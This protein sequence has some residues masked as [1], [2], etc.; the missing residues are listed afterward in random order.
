[1]AFP[2]EEVYD[3][4]ARPMDGKTLKSPVSDPVLMKLRFVNGKP[5]EA[6]LAPPLF[7]L[8]Y[9]AE[10][11]GQE[12]LSK[13]INASIENEDD[14]FCT[15]LYHEGHV[16]LLKED[17]P[18]AVRP[19]LLEKGLSND[20]SAQHVLFMRIFHRTGLYAGFLPVDKNRRVKY[21]PGTGKELILY[22]I[23]MDAEQNLQ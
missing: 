15:V 1:M 18:E 20:P 21:V 8:L 19:A 16:K 5:V 6:S 4:F 3:F 11:G 7:V 13:L 23:K 14:S 9:L 2:F 10:D 17:I 12:K 22:H